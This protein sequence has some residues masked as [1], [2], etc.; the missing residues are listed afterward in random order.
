MDDLSGTARLA[1]GNFELTAGRIVR[2][3]ITQQFGDPEDCG[4]GIIQLM[5]H[6]G[7]HLAHGRQPFALDQL[8]L[9]ALGVGDVARRSNHTGDA[10]GEVHERTGGRPEQPRFPVVP[11]SQKL[12]ATVGALSGNNRIQQCLDFFAALRLDALAEQR[13]NQLFR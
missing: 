9:H 8:V 1:V 10:T 11:A 12:G 7:D 2:D 6:A 4:E 13:P 3:R 5:G